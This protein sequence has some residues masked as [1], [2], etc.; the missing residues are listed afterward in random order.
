MNSMEDLEI[1]VKSGI[2]TNVCLSCRDN[3][4]KVRYEAITAAG[5]I[6][7][8]L[9]DENRHDIVNDLLLQYDF[10]TI[11]LDTLRSYA[12]EGNN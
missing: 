10:F 1:V 12:E 9:C 2:L 11:V 8:K 4:K 6:L 5:N 7:V 3:V